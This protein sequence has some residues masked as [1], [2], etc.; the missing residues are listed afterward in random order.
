MSQPP[1]WTP[2]IIQGINMDEYEV[3]SRDLVSR[4][5]FATPTR[6]GTSVNPDSGGSTSS[7]SD[8]SEYELATKPQFYTHHNFPGR[9]SFMSKPIHPVTFPSRI[10]GRGPV[11]PSAS[12]FLE[13]DSATPRRR[14][15]QRLSSGSSSVDFTDVS[16]S[17]DS[18]ASGRF[19]VH[20]EG[21]K[22]AI[23][24]RLLSQRSPWSSRRIVRNGDMPVASV[25]SCRHVFHAEC[26]ERETL[27]TCKSDPP[28]P[29]CAKSDEGSSPRQWISCNIISN[30]PRLKSCNEDG[31]SSRPWDCGQSGDC[32]EGA[33]QA[34]PRNTMLVLNRN[35][36]KKSLSFKGS[37]SAKEFPGKLKKTSGSHPLPLPSGWSSEQGSKSGPSTRR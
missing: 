9:R 34:P 8:G 13:F 33:L 23:C 32:V 3:P 5:F 29:V 24:E 35:R 6:E 36:M 27:K 16:E 21:F 22:C 20:S 25:L 10:P 14:E 2:P 7:Q 15:P 17:F 37:N 31:P 26:L 1:Q 19:S 18:E 12:G 4:P 11:D 28:C 30:F